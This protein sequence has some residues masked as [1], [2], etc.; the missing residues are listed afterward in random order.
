MLKPSILFFV[1]D[2]GFLG[3]AI[4]VYYEVLCI[5]AHQYYLLCSWNAA[6][7]SLLGSNKPFPQPIPLHVR[8][9]AFQLTILMYGKV[10]FSPSNYHKSLIFN[11]QLRNRT[12]YAIQLSKPGKFGPWGGFEDGFAFS[13]KNKSN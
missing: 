12:T 13:K 11:L 4:L 5:Y 2:G 3:N 10:Q 9:N 1:C 6:Y 8:S 7:E